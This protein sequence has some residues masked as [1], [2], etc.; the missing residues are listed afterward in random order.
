[1]NWRGLYAAASDSA[2]N[3]CNVEDGACWGLIFPGSRQDAFRSV[4]RS[5]AVSAWFE[6]LMADQQDVSGLLYRRNRYYDPQS[7]MFT[8]EDPIGIAGGLNLYGDANGDPN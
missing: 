6:S 2:G 5:D 7:G 8:Q 1:M 4:P 3:N